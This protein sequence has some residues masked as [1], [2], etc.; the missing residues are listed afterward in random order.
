MLRMFAPALF[1]ATMLSTAA[2]AGVL[3]INGD[4]TGGPTW[5]RTLSGAPPVGLS[6]VGTDVPYEVSAFT[7]SVSGSYDFLAKAEY[8]NFL[9]LYQ[10]TFNPLDQFSGV[11]IASDDFPTI[12]LSGFDYGLTTGTSY[13][14]V[15]S[16]FANTDFG[17]YELTISGPGDITLGSVGTV[18][19]PQSWV[20]LIAGFGLVGAAA[21]RRRT[22]ATA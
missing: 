7:V 6:G 13:F 16:G 19:E 11:L 3:V 17:A 15:A 2:S 8:D 10:G 20:M 22:A 4:T 21:R 1:A 12:G 5:N 9:H 18:P 14:V